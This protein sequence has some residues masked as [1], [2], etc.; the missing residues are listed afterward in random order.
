MCERARRL[1]LGLDG[2]P[3]E[4]DAALARLLQLADVLAKESTDFAKSA[5]EEI[6]KGVSEEFLSLRSSAKH[7]AGIYHMSYRAI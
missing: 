3:S 6:K 7:K 1:Y 2:E 5:V 4:A